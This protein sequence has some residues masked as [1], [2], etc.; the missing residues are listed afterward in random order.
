MTS[1][2]HGFILVRIANKGKKN[3]LVIP[4]RVSHSLTH[5]VTKSAD[6]DDVIQVTVFSDSISA[7]ISLQRAKLGR[8]ESN[9]EIR[10]A[11]VKL[12]ILP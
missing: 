9:L 2:S 8:P 11:I 1:D 10:Q 4:Q 5:H 3:E 6:I 12:E 7:N